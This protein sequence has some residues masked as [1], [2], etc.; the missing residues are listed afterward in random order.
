MDHV[1]SGEGVARYAHVQFRRNRRDRHLGSIQLYWGRTS[2][3]EFNLRR[4]SQIRLDA[5]STYKAQSTRLFS[6]TVPIDRLDQLEEEFRSHLVRIGQFFDRSPKRRQSFL[7]HEAVCHAGLMRRYGHGWST[8]DP[9]VVIDSEAQ[10]VYSS[11]DRRDADDA[12]IREQLQ[13][14]L[15]ETIPRK[16]DSLGVLPGGDLALVEVKNA[17]GSI[18]R[19]IIQAAGHLVRYSRLLA[20]SNLR[21]TIQAMIDQKTAAG[22]IPRGC[23]RLNDVPRIVP[24]FAAPVASSC[25]AAN[26]R[27]AIDNC[28]REMRAILRDAMFIRLD[29]AGGILDVQ[30]L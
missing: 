28:I 3:L 27:Q 5:D 20:F 1:R 4:G 11:R 14:S 23:P 18:D 19:A 8:G 25:W 16:L 6:K 15:S 29:D 13:L 7:K 24:C 22:V 9:L 2:P 12:E 17:G 26:W 30:S 21:D 10:I